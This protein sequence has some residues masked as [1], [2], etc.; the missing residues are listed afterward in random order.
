MSME[1]RRMQGVAVHVSGRGPG[2][3]LLHANGGDHR[4][5]SEVIPALSRTCTVYAV[6]WP[7]HGQSD[8]APDPTAIAFADLLPL[9]LSE[10]GGGPFALI[11]NSVGGFAALRTAIG[12]PDLVSRLVLV[13]PGGFTPR[14][15]FA[16]VTCKIMGSG[17][18]API[19]MRQLP[20]L[21]L[22]RSSGAVTAVKA[23]AVEASQSPEAVR[24]FASMWRSFGD[25]KHDARRDVGWLTVPTLLIWGT[26]DPV[27]PWLIDG[28]R[29]AKAIPG[30]TVVLLPCG[31]QAFL[32]MPPEFLDV[33][34]PFLDAAAT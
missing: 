8:P 16:L 34:G 12:R 6:D 28:R 9:I 11:G 10:L 31:H 18:V 20:R 4:E 17:P 26:R 32:E 19:A 27:L 5:F 22:R 23:R 14:T 3:V 1:V 24:T 30:A 25:P 7:G 29:A 2:V 15:P 21:Y 33:V 13:N